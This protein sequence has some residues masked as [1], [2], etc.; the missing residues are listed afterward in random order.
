MAI[1]ISRRQ[2]L[3]GLPSG[4]LAERIGPVARPVGRVEHI[5]QVAGRGA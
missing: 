1:D 3:Q 4:E 5:A 2:D